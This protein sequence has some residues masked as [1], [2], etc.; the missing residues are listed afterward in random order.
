MGYPSKLLPKKNYKTN[1]FKEF[2]QDFSLMRRVE[3]DIEIL[4]KFGDVTIEAIVGKPEEIYGY[5]ISLYSKCNKKDLRYFVKASEDK[6]WTRCAN[7][8]KK[9]E[10]DSIFFESDVNII[11]LFANEI[12]NKKFQIEK[13]VSKKGDDK[14]LRFDGIVKLEHKPLRSNYWHFELNVYENENDSKPIKKESKP[15]KRE[16]ARG[17]VNT[18]MK[19]IFS[20]NS[21]NSKLR[22]AFWKYRGIIPCYL[23]MKLKDLYN[24]KPSKFYEKL[25]DL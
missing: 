23:H 17:F 6:R 12:H 20:A 19:D 11:Y 24:R 7:P 14:I 21:P 18:T 10:F 9:N 3:S 13:S 2:A 1:S 22:I 25:A 4:D 5:S 8:P 16:S 15:W